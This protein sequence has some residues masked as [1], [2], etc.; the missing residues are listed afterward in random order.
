MPAEVLDLSLGQNQSSQALPHL[1]DGSPGGALREVTKDAA[2]KAAQHRLIQVHGAVA[3]AQDHDAL[4]ALRRPQTVPV[5]HELILD[6]P[7]RLVL[8]T[9][10]RPVKSGSLI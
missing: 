2:G 4:V 9:Q 5:L 1:K 8:C 10:G 6:L 3:G 7:H